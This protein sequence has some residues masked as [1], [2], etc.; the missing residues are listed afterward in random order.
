MSQESEV[1]PDDQPAAQGAEVNSSAADVAQS[2]NGSDGAAEQRDT[3]LREQARQIVR[4]F[5]EREASV[6]HQ[7][8]AHYVAELMDRIED[9]AF[10]PA[11]RTAAQREC[12]QVI[13]RIWRLNRAR[14]ATQLGYAIYQHEHFGRPRRVPDLAPQVAAAL[15]EPSAAAN[16]SGLD[17]LLSIFALAEVEQDVIRLLI[18]GY[19]LDSHTSLE[20][21]PGETV[22]EEGPDSQQEDALVEVDES[23]EDEESTPD[24]ESYKRQAREA[25]AALAPLLPVVTS[26]EIDNYRA[27]A[28]FANDALLKIHRLKSVVLERA[29]G[30]V[31]IIAQADE[32]DE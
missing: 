19:L 28:G 3:R 16:W 6:L 24:P 17:R 31:G 1:G 21:N 32:P 14:E 23:E 7:W 25:Q 5:G 2:A 18:N 15:T 4:E 8:M 30:E 13:D 20:E 27:V 12:A 29:L 9:P 22:E 10:S 26:I 11:E